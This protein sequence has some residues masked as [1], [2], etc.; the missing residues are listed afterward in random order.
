[1]FWIEIQCFRHKNNVFNYNSVFL[2]CNSGFFANFVDKNRVFVAVALV[3]NAIS[4]Y[5]TG[6]QFS[7]FIANSWF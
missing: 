2:V 3:V 4:H 5:N 7:V 1:M 6:L